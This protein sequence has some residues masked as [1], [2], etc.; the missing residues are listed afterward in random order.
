VR[1]PNRKRRKANVPTSYVID[2]QNRLVLNTATGVMTMD[3]ILQGRRQFMSDPDFDPDY[4]QLADLSAVTEIDLTSAEIKML[5]ETS[6]FSLTSRR[7]FVGDRP[8]IYGL[9]RMFSIVRGLRGDQQIRVF[10]T[11]ETALAWVLKKDK[12]A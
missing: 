11:R 9:A 1:P 10:R 12:A 8:E 5:A 3:D 6:P 4:S 2:K 7:A